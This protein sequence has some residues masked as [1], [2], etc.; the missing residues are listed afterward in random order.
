MPSRRS[1]SKRLSGSSPSAGKQ[2]GRATSSARTRS[3]RSSRL[4]ESFSKT[5]R[6]GPAGKG[7]SSRL[8]MAKVPD[9][10]TAVPGPKA[11]AIIDRDRQYVSA[12]YTRAYPFVMARGQGA[13]VED[14]DGNLF[15]DCAAGI[16]VAATGHS[17]PH[18]VSA[19]T[20]QAQ[21]FLHM[22]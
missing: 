17:H 15:L 14:V 11:R 2:D 6:P 13:V 7:S 10:R 9:I 5:P 4:A 1:P 19:I 20:T 22:S 8:Q 12:S 21:K 16:A 18:V 3:A